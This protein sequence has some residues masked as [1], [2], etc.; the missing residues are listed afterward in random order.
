MQ[1]LTH[2]R[3]LQFSHFFYKVITHSCGK[4]Y[5]C[6]DAHHSSFADGVEEEFIWVS[7]SGEWIGKMWKHKDTVLTNNRGCSQSNLDES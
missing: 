6:I 2:T 5:V 1:C 3:N 4:G 7:A